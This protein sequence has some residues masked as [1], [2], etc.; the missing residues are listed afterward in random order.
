VESA[1]QSACGARRDVAR[2]SGMAIAIKLL[3]EL[4]SILRFHVDERRRIEQSREL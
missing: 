1:L 2:A 4:P 3:R